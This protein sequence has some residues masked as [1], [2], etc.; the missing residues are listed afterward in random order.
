MARR[1]CVC[2]ALLLAWGC[3]DSKAPERSS[4]VVAPSS[5]TTAELETPPTRKPSADELL[6]DE[7][8]IRIEANDDYLRENEFEGLAS[9]FPWGRGENG[10]WEG[11]GV[12][13]PKPLQAVTDEEMMKR[14][15]GDTAE[16]IDHEHALVSVGRRKLPGAMLAFRKAM[17]HEAPWEVREMAL[18]G[19]VEH[20]G[21]EALPLMWRF[22]KDDPMPQ[23]R[24]QA[25]WAI[26]LYG[27][28]EA[29]KA[30]DVGLSD[31]DIGVRGMAILAVW[32]LKD[33]PDEA[34]PILEAAAESDNLLIFQE[35]FYNLG[36]M[37]WRRAGRILSGW[38]MRAKGKKQQLALY[39][40][41][42]WVREYPDLQRNMKGAP[43]PRR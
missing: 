29:R 21:K 25:I 20:G 31:E 33:R 28:D 30:I 7:K 22:L 18:S 4:L 15:M 32:A 36:R 39:H 26:A 41:R 5:S 10:V 16:R 23:L 35:A 19:L 24:G 11:T 1:L 13:D 14:A 34:L 2:V 38:V 3:A 9:S 6:L 27:E 40:Y 37:P 42:G 8:T 17:N 12:K 43:S